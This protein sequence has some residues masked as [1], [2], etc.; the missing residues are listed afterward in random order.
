MPTSRK[1]T[2][3]AARDSFCPLMCPQIQSGGSS[4][5]KTSSKPGMQ[6][7]PIFYQAW[8]VT[9]PPTWGY[10]T[11]FFDTAPSFEAWETH[12]YLKNQLGIVCA[13][14]GG[15][16]DHPYAPCHPPSVPPTEEYLVGHLTNY[17]HQMSSWG[18]YILFLY[19]YIEYHMSLVSVLRGVVKMCLC[20]LLTRSCPE[21]GFCFSLCPIEA[22]FTLF[23]ILFCF[24]CARTLGIFPA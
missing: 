10:R 23:I 4:C 12:R 16:L 14:G 17:C 13:R 3:N 9:V 8:C 21:V 11:P 6:L 18:L 2:N 7:D 5:W 19:C 22:N 24:N 1:K 20:L 15:L